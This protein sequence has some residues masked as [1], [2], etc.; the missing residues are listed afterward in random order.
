MRILLFSI[1]ASFF[2]SFLGAQTFLGD[3]I[4]ANE[5]SIDRPITLHARQFRITGGYGLS[6]ISR[7]FNNNNDAIHLRDD[8]L[9]SIRHRFNVDIKYGLTEYVQLNAAIAQS[10][11]VVREQ[12]R[13]I[14]PLQPEPV[15][16][17][18]VL[19]E[20]SG[21]DDLYVGVD[22]RAP[23]NTR[24]LDIAITLSATLPVA[25]NEPPRPEH[26]FQISPGDETNTHTFIYRYNYPLG[27]G[28]VIPQ[29]GGMIKYRATRWAISARVDYQHGLTE[30]ESF[31]WRHQLKDDGTF[32]Y[33]KDPFTYRLPDTYSYFAEAEYQPLPW[34]DLFLN[35][36][37]LNAF[38]G[39][40]S[41]QQ[42]MKLAIPYQTSLIAAP[43]F[44]IIVTPKFWLRERINI[45]MAGKNSEAPFTFQTTLM[46]NF[47]PFK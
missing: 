32:E 39:W 38:Y 29:V 1:A 36:S 26:T 31:E 8:G 24:K 20:Y 14:F 35:V 30:G 37:G 11:N 13:Y 45:S 47:F 16:A 23:L 34:L 18:N 27:R 12:T 10:S 17:Q 2:P 25:R 5:R 44:E 43:G 46:Y 21:L 19:K 6:V 9:S 4:L 41:S 7:R 28:V 33:R 15:V 42:D 40:T 22:L 3:S